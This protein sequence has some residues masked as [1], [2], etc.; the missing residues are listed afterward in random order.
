M[1]NYCENRCVFNKIENNKRRCYPCF[2]GP[3][4][5]QVKYCNRKGTVTPNSFRNKCLWIGLVSL[6]AANAVL[7]EAEIGNPI[8]GVQYHHR[9]WPWITMKAQSEHL[10]LSNNESSK[11]KSRKILNAVLSKTEIGNPLWGV[12][13]PHHIWPW[14][15]MKAQ[16]QHLTL[17]N[18][19]SSKSKLR[20]FW[21]AGDLSGYLYLP[22]IT[23]IWMSHK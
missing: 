9:I 14:I 3:I 22:V 18:N 10:T 2:E 5:P 20:K 17:S 21:M 23:L 8:W 4:L 13:Y 16:S 11:S 19:E 6:Q 1:I 15:T 12:Q 7:S